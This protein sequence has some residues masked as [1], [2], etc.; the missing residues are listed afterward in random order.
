MADPKLVKHLIAIMKGVSKYSGITGE[1][2]VAH[3]RT[4]QIHFRLA[5]GVDIIEPGESPKTRGL[6]SDI[7]DF[8]LL[9]LESGAKA[10]FVSPV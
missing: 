1:D 9:T 10:W 6:A 2:P 8:F 3:L 4:Y 5:T 7:I